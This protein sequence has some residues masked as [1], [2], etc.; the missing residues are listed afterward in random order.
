MKSQWIY[1]EHLKVRCVKWP[2]FFPIHEE[3]GFCVNLKVLLA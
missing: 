2:V 3:A 1:V